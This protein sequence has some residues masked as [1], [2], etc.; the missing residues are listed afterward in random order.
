M[1]S[2]VKRRR[3]TMKKRQRKKFEFIYLDKVESD[4]QTI[5]DQ[6]F[7]KLYSNQIISFSLKQNHQRL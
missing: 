3:T 5:P 2:R 7:A 4:I 6:T 1:P